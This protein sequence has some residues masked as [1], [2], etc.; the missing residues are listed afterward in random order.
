[1]DSFVYLSSMAA[2]ALDEQDWIAVTE[3]VWPTILKS[4][5]LPLYGN[6]LPTYDV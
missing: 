3:P 2:F 1:M 6:N 4:Y 5:F